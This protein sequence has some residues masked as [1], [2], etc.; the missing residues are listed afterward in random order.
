MAAIF[1]Q[2]DFSELEE[3][4]IEVSDY[5]NTVV[6]TTPLNKFSCCC[7]DDKVRIHFLNYLGTFDAVNFNKPKVLHEPTSS[8]YK[9]SLPAA[10]SKTSTGF[11]RFNVVSNDSKEAKNNC[12][13]EPDMKWLQELAD[14]PKAL[15]E[16]KGIQSQADEYLPVKLL[17]TKFEKQKNERE[18]IYDFVIQYKLSN[19]FKTIRN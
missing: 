12:Y 6:A 19:E 2:I 17:D 15:E 7:S 10:L 9:R 5:T 14:S 18:Y 16:W 11:E 8:E 4:S 3:Y 1:P 13:K